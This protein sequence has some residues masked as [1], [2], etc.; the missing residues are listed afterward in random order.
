MTTR[1]L[2]GLEIFEQLWKGTTL[3][4]FLWSLIEVSQFVQEEILEEIVDKSQTD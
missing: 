2:P 1:I 4:S 3:W